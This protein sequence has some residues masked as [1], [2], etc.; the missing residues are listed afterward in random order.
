MKLNPGVLEGE[1]VTGEELAGFVFFL[2]LLA[3]VRL[4]GL[5]E[6]GRSIF[7]HRMAGRL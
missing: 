4:L 5:T 1:V 6:A 7:F 2:L 3:E